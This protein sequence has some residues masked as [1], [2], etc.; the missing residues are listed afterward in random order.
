[1]G[2]F[3]LFKSVV[4]KDEKS[5]TKQLKILLM[6]IV[7]GIFVFFLPS[8][9]YAIFGLSTDLNI[10]SEEKY[11]GCVDCLLKPTTCKVTNENSAG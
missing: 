7:A 10:V 5:F 3:D 2:T 11:K 6:R 9:V 8:I 4:D 1:M